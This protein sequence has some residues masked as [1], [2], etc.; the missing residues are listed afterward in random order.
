MRKLLA[1]TAIALALLAPGLGQLHAQD[2]SG[3]G[4][5]GGS[6]GSA[7]T[8]DT[9]GTTGLM[10]TTPE[11]KSD[12]AAG[13]TGTTVERGDIAASPASERLRGAAAGMRGGDLVGQTVYGA[14]GEEVGEVSDII[15]RR[16]TT[17]PEALVGVGGFL[18]IGE[19]D[20]AIPMSQLEMRGDR[21]TTGMTKESLGA[22]D[23]YEA[24][25]YDRWD[26]NSAI[27]GGTGAN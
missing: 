13:T 19:R 27:N 8:G 3:G 1:T 26:R 20:V 21:L 11:A 24:G 4:A 22:M 6:A 2:S 5:G 7:G 17:E 14:N 23:A 10:T 12:D 15:A 25:G 16:G 18:G 9:G